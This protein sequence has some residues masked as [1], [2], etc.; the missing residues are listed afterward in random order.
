[1]LQLAIGLFYLL[2]ASTDSHTN[3]RFEDNGNGTITDRKTR[4]IGLKWANCFGKKQWHEAVA[5]VEKLASGTC[6]LSDGSRPGSWRLPTKNELSTLFFWTGSGMFSGV[7]SHIYWSSSSFGAA[8]AWY[9]HLNLGDVGVTPKSL[10]YYVWPVR[11]GP[12][13]R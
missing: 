4:L 7:R 3:T 6:G 8:K 10:Y 12:Y 13:N 9:V 5:M 2:N 1:M 11:T